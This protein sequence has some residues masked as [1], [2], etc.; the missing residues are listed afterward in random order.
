MIRSDREVLV[1]EEQRRLAAIL[2]ADAAGFSRLMAAD[3]AGTLERLGRVM[4]EIV[5]PAIARFGGKIV[6]SA[7]DSFMAEFASA[8]NAVRCAVEIQA[9]VA[10]AEGARPPAERMPFR[11]GVNLGDV[12]AKDGTIYGDGVNIAARLEPMAEP[13]G[14]VIG[15][16]VQAQ[17]K[18]K[19][20]FA[21]FDLGQHSLKNIGDPVRVFRVAF[22]A[23][24]GGQ[25]LEE[26]PRL[27]PPEQPSIAVLPFED[28]SG[29][30]RDNAYFGD[31]ISE[32]IITALSKL[33][34]FFV[35]AR[36]S[37]FAYKGKSPDIRQVA[38]ELGVLY[39]LEGSV[40]KS[41]ERLRVTAQLIDA[42][43]GMHLWAERYDRALSDIF[44]VQDE[45]T[46]NVI[47]AIEPQ[48]YLA[49]NQRS[50]SR[51]PESL[52]AWGCV[53]RAMPYVWVW[54]AQDNE[55]GVPWLEQALAIDPDYGRAN[56]LLSWVFGARAHLGLADP[57]PMLAKA[58]GHAR[59]ALLRDSGDPWAHLALGYVHMVARQ[60]QPAIDQLGEAIERNPSFA[61]AHM[62]MGSSH[63]Y[64]GHPDEGMHHVEVSMRLSPR[65]SVHAANLSTMGTCHFIAGRYAEALEFQRR[66]V[67]LSPNFGTAW[68]SLTAASALAGDL[69]LAAEALAEARR[70]Q[71]GLSLE[72]VDRHHPIVRRQDRDRYLDGLRRAGLT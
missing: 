37:T 18:G 9:A 51:A 1:A 23:A 66:A 10:S 36:N 63:A 52:D 43:T 14:I 71:P 54:T 41:G 56:S 57:E 32:D 59:R 5:A 46:D 28:L 27:V 55:A 68:R 47:G 35:I 61:L 48:L 2:A 30:D 69:D 44:A 8:L 17:V 72:W 39:V 21:L 13:G 34:A 29:G 6:G 58:I 22:P 40:R 49:E 53:M 12:I 16:S 67:Q 25:G 31:G 45:I 65:D 19:L 64:G 20:P 3:E 15:E 4:E 38:R 24:G 33:R 50:R 42:R 26:Q 11:M 60:Y 7:G 70:G 62:V